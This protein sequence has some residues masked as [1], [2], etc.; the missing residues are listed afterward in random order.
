MLELHHDH[1][2][3]HDGGDD[4][5]P[6]AGRSMMT[7]SVDNMGWEGWLPM[8]QIAC[9]PPVIELHCHPAA[10]NQLFQVHFEEEL[11]LTDNFSRSSLRMSGS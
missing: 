10:H 11:M 9:W 6:G 8:S 2:D 7:W 3:H 5:D 1:D 4:G